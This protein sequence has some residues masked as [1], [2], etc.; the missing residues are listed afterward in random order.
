MNAVI[1]CIFKIH[2]DVIEVTVE[3]ARSYLINLYQFKYY[4]TNNT[5]K[6]IS[7]MWEVCE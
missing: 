5:E 3:C 1:Q 2:K 6:S 7:K 4:N